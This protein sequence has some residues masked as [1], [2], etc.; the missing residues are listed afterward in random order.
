MEKTLDGKSVDKLEEKLSDYWALATRKTNL[1][2]RIA[3]AEGEKHTVTERIFRKVLADYEDELE[4]IEVKLAPLKSEIDKFKDAINGEIAKIDRR[5]AELEDELAEANFRSRVGEF[6]DGDLRKAEDRIQP[7]IDDVRERKFRL[8]RQFDACDIRI[9]SRGVKRYPDEVGGRDDSYVSDD[10]D[11]SAHDVRKPAAWADEVEAAE[12]RVQEQSKVD[13]AVEV[14][15]EEEEEQ[16]P[17]ASKSREKEDLDDDD[18]LA[19]L[20]DPDAKKASRKRASSADPESSSF[21]N[22]VISSG[23][24]AGR[25]IPLLPMTMTIGREHDNNIELKDPEVGRYHARILYER[26]KFMLED[27]DSSTGTWVNGERVQ[28]TALAD[29]DEIRVGNTELT[30]EY[31]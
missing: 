8:E 31:A 13:V 14:D 9:E 18:P 3:K 26:G 4:S 21:P 19:A 24:N 5:L 1:E 17:V 15:E 22:L 29:G 7:K 20:A 28:Q 11:L 10:D 27:L 6:E 25:A 16:V 30:V 23:P 12:A 2:D